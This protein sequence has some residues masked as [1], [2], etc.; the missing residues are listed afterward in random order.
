MVKSHDIGA[1]MARISLTVT[2]AE[3]LKLCK[4]A[5]KSGLSLNA[6]IGAIMSDAIDSQAVVMMRPEI[7]RENRPQFGQNLPHKKNETIY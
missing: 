4:L 1:G 6:F 3:K 7:I 2:E 5:D